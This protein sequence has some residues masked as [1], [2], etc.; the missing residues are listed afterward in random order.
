MNLRDTFDLS[1]QQYHAGLDKLWSALGL[2]DVQDEDV[3]TLAARAIDN[4]ALKVLRELFDIRP[5]DDLIYDIRS[6]EG[7]GWD[8]PLVKRWAA[9]LERAEALIKETP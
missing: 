7:K 3:F 6:S 1:P 8:G 9:V 5:L 2:T 4:E